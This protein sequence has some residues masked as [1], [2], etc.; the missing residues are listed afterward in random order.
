MLE[1]ANSLLLAGNL[2]GTLKLKYLR[3]EEFSESLVQTAVGRQL[4]FHVILAEAR[5]ILRRYSNTKEST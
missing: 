1:N 3:V 2:K 5:R 4:I